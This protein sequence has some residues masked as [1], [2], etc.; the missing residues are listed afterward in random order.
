MVVRVNFFYKF[1]SLK[2]ELGMY[3]E[4]S[5]F[6]NTVVLPAV[7][8]NPVDGPK[9]L[10]PGSG[11]YYGFAIHDNPK[12]LNLKTNMPSYE[13]KGFMNKFFS[14]SNASRVLSKYWAALS[15]KDKMMFFEVSQSKAL[16]K[17]KSFPQ[18]YVVNKSS[19]QMDLSKVDDTLELGKAPV[20][21]GIFFDM[22]K[23]TK[24]EHIMGFKLYF[25]NHFN[26]EKLDS[27]K[28][29]DQWKMKLQ[30]IML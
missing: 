2:F 17:S 30:K 10:N 4:V 13:K 3:T 22:T 26:K 12:D 1:L 24:G 7:M 9:R 15:A 18:L 20:N 28:R 8:Y 21:L 14:F 6:S 29:M 25:E 11:F 16:V 27:F 19:A 5:F 23:F